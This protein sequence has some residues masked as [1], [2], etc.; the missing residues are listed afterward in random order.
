[1][2]FVLTLLMCSAVGNVCLPPHQHPIIFDDAYDCMKEGYQMSYDKII[3][4]GKEQVNE[5]SIYIKFG[6]NPYEE[7]ST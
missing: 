2:K 4:I 7:T 3:E 1:M 5:Q 6:C